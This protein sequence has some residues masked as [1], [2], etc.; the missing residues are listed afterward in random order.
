MS[1]C[2]F[3]FSVAR[4]LFLFHTDKTRDVSAGYHNVLFRIVTY[5]HGLYY[6]VTYY[7]ACY[8]FIYLFTNVLYSL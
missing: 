4:D 7:V 2:S 8:L 1:Q 5:V 6:T 3:F